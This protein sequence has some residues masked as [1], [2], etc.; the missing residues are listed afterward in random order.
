MRYF[1]SYI[2]GGGGSYLVY[3]ETPQ[4]ARLLSY[5][6]GGGSNVLFIV[7]VAGVDLRILRRG[8]LGRNSSR[9]V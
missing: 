6:R 1:I 7:K 8:V 5:K 4:G 9:V 2:Y 3:W